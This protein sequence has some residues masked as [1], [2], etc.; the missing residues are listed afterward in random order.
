MATFVLN[1]A[2][3]SITS[4]Y[5]TDTHILSTPD[6]WSFIS[7]LRSTLPTQGSLTAD[8]QSNSPI[9]LAT[10]QNDPLS[11]IGVTVASS[12]EGN[13]PLPRLHLKLELFSEHQLNQ[14]RVYPILL[15]IGGTLQEDS[16]TQNPT[17]VLGG[18]PPTL[19]RVLFSAR[20]NTSHCL[21]E[22][23]TGSEG[24]SRASSVTK[25]DSTTKMD[26]L[27]MAPAAYNIGSVQTTYPTISY[28]NE[29]EHEEHTAEVHQDHPTEHTSDQFIK[30]ISKEP[31]AGNDHSDRVTT[32]CDTGKH[33]ENTY[34]VSLQAPIQEDLAPDQTM[35]TH[36]VSTSPPEFQDDQP[37][38]K[39]TSNTE[40]ATTNS[41]AICNR[42]VYDID[43][44][45]AI[46]R[47]SNFSL[48]NLKFSDEALTGKQYSSD[49]PQCP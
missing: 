10:S 44:L 18:S 29:T 49:A 39:T 25:L 5:R 31:T 24:H 15:E 33:G 19:F 36:A 32:A 1:D 42:K 41:L 22:F 47:E 21:S 48:A 11:L 34:Q 9:S 16:T 20:A 35:D 46:G 17:L 13:S 12:L 14:G 6:P 26:E 4:P 40:H 23:S 30:A 38:K 28:A 8:Q 3:N 2:D 7:S 37:V 27:T 45:L 43:T